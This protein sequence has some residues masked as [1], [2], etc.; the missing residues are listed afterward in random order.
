MCVLCGEAGLTITVELC[1][2]QEGPLV[3]QVL[4]VLAGE[5]L[6]ISTK[7]NRA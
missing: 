7:A 5:A 6:E 4:L 3:L 2:Q 1:M